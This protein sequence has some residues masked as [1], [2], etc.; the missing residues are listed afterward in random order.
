MLAIILWPQVKIPSTTSTLF[1]IELVQIM[2]LSFELECEKN[3]SNQKEARIDPFLK[4]SNMTQLKAGP[5]YD[6]NLLQPAT[7]SCI[8]NN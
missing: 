2:Y 8:A 5:H 1:S 6:A 4:I 7:G 3:K